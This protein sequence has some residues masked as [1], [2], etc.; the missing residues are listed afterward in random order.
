MELKIRTM[1]PEDWDA[2]KAIY[3]EGID[4]KIATFQKGTPTY[5][6]WDNSHVKRCRLVALMNEAIVGWAALS[7]VSSRCVYSGVAELSIY[8]KTDCRG[9]KVGEALLLELIKESEA[10]GIW[11]LQSGIFEINK[12]S[13]ALHSKLGFRMVGYR[14]RIAQDHDGVW[15]NTVLMER[16]STI[17]P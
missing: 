13:Q 4:T 3:Q 14:E 8:V 15:Q 6:E 11:T 17:L 2:V 1:Q 5:E 9:K 16:R 10:E 7:P 12:A